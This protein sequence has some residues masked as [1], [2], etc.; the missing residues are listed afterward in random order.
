[1][2]PIVL[3]CCFGHLMKMSIIGISVLHATGRTSHFYASQVL[4]IHYGK[5][6]IYGALQPS[7]NATFVLS[8]WEGD[9]K[10]V[11]LYRLTI[12]VKS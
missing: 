3:A 2:V 5:V 7:Q 6:F 9:P 1:M 11:G 8:V 4:S 10:A 12:Q